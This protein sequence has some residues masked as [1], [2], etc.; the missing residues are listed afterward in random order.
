[1]D[2]IGYADESPATEALEWMIR[3]YAVRSLASAAL[4]VG[5]DFQKCGGRRPPNHNPQCN[6]A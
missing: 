4:A 5:Y 3:E 1:M 6:F 2:T